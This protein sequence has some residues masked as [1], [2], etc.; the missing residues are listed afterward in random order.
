MP[1]CIVSG[2]RSTLDHTGYELAA[3]TIYTVGHSTRS[4]EELLTLLTRPGAELVAD[5]RAFPSSRR[6]PQFNRPVLAAWLERSGVA[7]TE[8]VLFKTRNSELWTTRAPFAK[9]FVAVD[10][11]GADWLV[12]HGTKL[13]GLIEDLST[14]DVSDPLKKGFAYLIASVN[15]YRLEETAG[16]S[17]RGIL[18]MLES[19]H[20]HGRPPWWLVL[21]PG[22]AI[23][24]TI[25]AANLVGDALREHRQRHIRQCLSAPEALAN[26]VQLHDRRTDRVCHN[27]YLSWGL[28]ITSRREKRSGE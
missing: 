1:V 18:Q 20:P 4:A 8:R 2:P 12:A 11:T 24:T 19:G 15:E 22:L 17:F 10:A 21:F 5:V 9:D 23:T 6:H 16:H 26:V 28:W 14:L 3:R 7:G 25:L 27:A 13:V